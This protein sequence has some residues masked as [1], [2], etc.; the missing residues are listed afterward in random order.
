[1]LANQP[2]NRSNSIVVK[3]VNDMR[4]GA[5]SEIH[6]HKRGKE[7]ARYL[8]P[9]EFYDNDCLTF[10][11]QTNRY[12][13]AYVV[14]FV[15]DEALTYRRQANQNPLQLQTNEHKQHH[16]QIG[17]SSSGN[18]FLVSQCMRANTQNR[19]HKMRLM[20]DRNKNKRL[21]SSSLILEKNCSPFW[22]LHF[23]GCKCFLI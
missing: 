5:R 8:R 4:S 18:S 3:V 14:V 15:K 12:A 23:H 17:N 10:S 11:V 6:R 20:R 22:L 19:T 21:C 2:N 7:I 1:M 16:F 13:M 9:L